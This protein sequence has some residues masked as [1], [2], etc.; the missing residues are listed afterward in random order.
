MLCRMST[1]PRQTQTAS[2]PPALGRPGPQLPLNLLVT[3]NLWKEGNGKQAPSI[4]L[5]KTGYKGGPGTIP[6]GVFNRPYTIPAGFGATPKGR[7][8]RKTRRA[9]RKNRKSRKSRR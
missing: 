7:K 6:P 5:P 1:P 3:K 4:T 2:N 9:N 8:S